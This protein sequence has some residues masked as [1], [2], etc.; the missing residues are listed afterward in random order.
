M[1][2]ENIREGDKLLERLKYTSGKKRIDEFLKK[3][4]YEQIDELE[5]AIEYHQDCIIKLNFERERKEFLLNPTLQ[6]RIR[7]LK[8]H[9]FEYHGIRQ[10]RKKKKNKFQ[11]EIKSLPES[12][13]DEWDPRE[14]SSMLDTIEDNI[15]IHRLKLQMIEEEIEIRKE[16]ISNQDIPEQKPRKEKKYTPSIL[17]DIPLPKILKVKKQQR[18]KKVKKDKTC[19]L[20]LKICILGKKDVGISTWF[21]NFNQSSYDLERWMLHGFGYGVKSIKLEDK[22]SKFQIWFINPNRRSFE[23]FLKTTFLRGCLGAFLVYDITSPESLSSIPEWINLIREKCGDIPIY[24]LGNNCELEEL[25]EL[26]KKQA[27]DL[28]EKFNLTGIYKISISNKINLDLP[29]E[30]ISE[31]YFEK[32]FNKS[33]SSKGGLKS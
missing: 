2:K 1:G 16:I 22:I 19:D 14:L 7:D 3:D 25:Q 23:R 27:E 10:K 15:I 30:R 33:A 28:V 21:K 11:K 17:Y 24:L 6:G 4:V 13:R 31:L 32:Y 12:N 5:G 8:K 9:L 26:S 18:I 29:F 20:L